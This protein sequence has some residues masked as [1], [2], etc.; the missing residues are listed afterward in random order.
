MAKKSMD[1]ICDRIVVRGNCDAV[2]GGR[3]VPI[4]I[5]IVPQHKNVVNSAKGKQ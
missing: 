2:L 1:S 4:C 3:D 5:E